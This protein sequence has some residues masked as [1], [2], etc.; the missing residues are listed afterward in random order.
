MYIVALY[1]S[2]H[3]IYLKACVVG[4]DTFNLKYVG[5]HLA[6]RYEIVKV[7]MPTEHKYV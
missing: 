3:L 2:P 7:C 4:A 6:H 1:S 5:Q